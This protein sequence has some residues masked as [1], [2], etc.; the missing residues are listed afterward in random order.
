M[1]NHPHVRE[2]TGKIDHFGP[3]RI[4]SARA[5][6]P[7]PRL[8]RAACGST[9]CPCQPR[10]PRASARALAGSISSTRNRS[11][12]YAARCRVITVAASAA[13]SRPYCVDVLDDLLRAR[14]RSPPMSALIAFFR[15]EAFEQHLQLAR[16]HR[17]DAEAETG[18]GNCRRAGPWHRIFLPRSKATSR[19]RRKRF[20]CKFGNDGQFLLHQRALTGRHAPGQCFRRTL[21]HSC[22]GR[23]WSQ[24]AGTICADTG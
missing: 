9:R 6:R 4:S 13:R 19:N 21:F 16:P 12:H 10:R 11:R 23:R 8:R 3:A 5:G 1:T 22:A 17:S 14:A 2:M 18:R 15:H 7:R 24:P 20:I